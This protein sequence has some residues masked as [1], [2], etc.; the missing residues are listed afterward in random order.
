MKAYE[1]F[2]APHVV[3]GNGTSEQIGKRLVGLGVTKCLIVTGKTLVKLGAVDRIRSFVEAE[4][5]A[6]DVYDGCLP[7]APDYTCL[8][9]RELILSNGYDGVIGFGGG[10]NIDTAKVASLMAGVPGEIEELHDYSRQGTLMKDD[11]KRPNIFVTV[12]TTGGTGA[13]TTYTGVISSTT[14]HLKFSCGNENAIADLAIVD[15]LLTLGSPE[16]L[17]VVCGLD[18]LAHAVENVV[19]VQQNDFSNMMML[20]CIGRVWKWLPIAVKYPDDIEAREQLAWAAH[21]AEAN[22][23]VPNGHA[24][25]VAIGAMYHIVHG[26]CCSMVLPTV[27]RHFSQASEARESI[28]GIAEKIGVPVTGDPI[29]DGNRVA[30]AILNFYK[31]FGLKPLREEL[32]AREIDDDK[33]TF[34]SK[35]IPLVLD[36]FKSRLW[37]PPIHNSEADV[38]KVLGMIYDET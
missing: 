19:G 34:I 30:D 14:L 33:E 24:I 12:P 4:G 21:Q 23:A 16:S 38:A 37:T 13:E 7:D 10:S 36:D 5:I 20:E 1:K 6:C 15:P 35:A 17:T 31:G 8:E 26:H 22:G 32:K 29:K 3:F 2:K 11:Y 25:G 28:R 18:A 27:V 9:V